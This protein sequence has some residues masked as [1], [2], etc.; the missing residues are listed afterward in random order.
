MNGSGTLPSGDVFG[1]GA[2]EKESFPS[3]A[4]EHSR[5]ELGEST[6]RMENVSFGTGPVNYRGEIPD[7]YSRPT[8]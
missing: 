3:P 1:I 2:D 5:L 6:L 4:M 8:Q 7:H